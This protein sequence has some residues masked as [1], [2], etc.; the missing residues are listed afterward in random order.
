MVLNRTR[1]FC[2]SSKVILN[3]IV[4]FFLI[5]FL[6]GWRLIAYGQDDH[7]RNNELEVDSIVFFEDY[8]DLL[9][10][11]IYTNTKWNTLDIV[12]DDNTL[13]LRPNNS[14]SLGLGFNY[15]SYGL[16]IAIGLPKSSS[17]KEKYGSTTRLDLQF[18]VYSKKFGIDVYGQYYKGYYNDNPQDF[19]NWNSENYPLLPDMEVF[20][21]GLNGF[22]IFNSEKFSYRAAYVRNQ[23]Q[24]KSAGS[25]TAGIFGQFDIVTT[26]QGF[27]PPELADTIQ[28]EFNL[29]SFN[30]TAIGLTAGYLYTWVISEHFFLN[31]GLIPGFGYQ[32][33]NLEDTDGVE[34]TKNAPAVQLTAKGAF[35]YDSRFFYAGISGME[36]WRNFEYKGYELDL[37]T[38]QLK[39][40]IGKRFNIKRKK[41]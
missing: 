32:A 25:F 2:I 37:A 16:G 27:I 22:Y 38:E 30:T 40:F 8:S 26:D 31:V 3:T 28:F 33:I 18:N 6:S 14:T 39:V 24:R 17:S 29:K 13:K 41:R 23:V 35:G 19:I 36:I 21:I 20:S 9:A 12:K 7:N 10:L 5:F 15:K 4:N 34:S 1:Y 11:R